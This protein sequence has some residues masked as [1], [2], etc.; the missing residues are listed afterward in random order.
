MRHL[1]V[2]EHFQQ[3][4]YYQE[5]EGSDFWKEDIRSHVRKGP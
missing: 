5:I 4:D 2:Y 3:S 1:K